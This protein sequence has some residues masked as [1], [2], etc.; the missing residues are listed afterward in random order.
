M[1]GC[2]GTTGTL[3]LARGP[4]AVLPVHGRGSRVHLHPIVPGYHNARRLAGCGSHPGSRRGT[5]RR[6]GQRVA[7]REFLQ[8]F[9]QLG[10]CATHSTRS[11][12]APE[13]LG[14]TCRGR[15]LA[16]ARTCMHWRAASRRILR[17][18]P[19]PSCRT[20]A[21]RARAWPLAPS[22]RARFKVSLHAAPEDCRAAQGGV[23]R[24]AGCSGHI[25]ASARGAGREARA[26]QSSQA[27]RHVHGIPVSCTRLQVVM[28]V[29][30]PS[31]CARAR[32]FFECPCNSY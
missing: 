31:S 23:L 21:S 29:Y 6:V 2:A 25:G 27:R 10:L 20:I 8:Q 28:H 18:S 9:Q 24:A 3:R 11:G 26:S 5:P 14:H 16:R 19:A 15:V 12:A 7:R 32:L 30:R 17:R 13:R 22:P 4:R 1:G